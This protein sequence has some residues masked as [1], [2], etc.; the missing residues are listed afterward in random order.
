ML[1]PGSAR[2]RLSEDVP[3]ELAAEYW[4]ASQVLPF[5]EEASA[6]ISRRLLQRV[7]S[8]KAGAG[9]GG[10]A[11]QVERAIASPAMPDYLKEALATYAKLARLEAHDVKSFRC[12]T[13]TRVNEGEALLA[14]RGAQ[15]PLR[16]LLRP[17]GPSCATHAPADRGE[18]DPGPGG[19]PR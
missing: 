12:E 10:L 5:S 17:A 9:Y 8:W 7:L 13:I 1:P 14:A 18:V 11:N 3:A 2:A 4:T 6:A 16:V 15:A 19:R